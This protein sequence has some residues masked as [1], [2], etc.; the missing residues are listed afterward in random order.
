[1]TLMKRE[2]HS[3]FAVPVNNT[4]ISKHPG[5]DNKEVDSNYVKLF[6]ANPEQVKREI[7]DQERR[8]LEQ[9]WRL[10][11]DQPEA[12]FI[13]EALKLLDARQM[14]TM[15]RPQNVVK[16]PSPVL[17]EPLIPGLSAM[18]IE[19]PTSP[20]DCVDPFAEETITVPEQERPQQETSSPEEERP[21]HVSGVSSDSVSS[22]DDNMA[23]DMVMEEGVTLT[24]LDISTVQQQDQGP[25]QPR[26][27]FYFY[28]SSDGQPIFL[29]ALNIQML[30]KQFGSL[31]NCPP[32]IEAEVSNSLYHFE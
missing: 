20:V 25:G 24:D 21:R 11:K 28:Q 26:Q 19:S 7:L 4:F 29:H 27:V 6:T 5:L 32:V 2:R 23:T 10:E 1:M 13:Q 22:G 14:E 15:L 9:Q 18:T 3:M 17:K 16:P 12:C 31:E 30:V 8:E